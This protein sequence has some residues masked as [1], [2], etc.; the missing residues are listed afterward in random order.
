MSDRPMDILE[1]FEQFVIENYGDLY[2]ED[3]CQLADID[4]DNIDTKNEDIRQEYRGKILR[5]MIDAGRK[6]K[7][8][9][10]SYRFLR[11]GD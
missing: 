5:F 8:G 9:Q 4:I 7:V 1:S 11:K 6:Y 3:I 2:W 10:I